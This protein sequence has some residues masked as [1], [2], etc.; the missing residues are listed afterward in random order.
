MTHDRIIFFVILSV[1]VLGAIVVLKLRQRAIARRYLDQVNKEN[2]ETQEFVLARLDSL[3]KLFADASISPSD[4]RQ[5]TDSI[6][7]ELESRNVR[8]DLSPL[9]A[10]TRGY[11]DGEISKRGSV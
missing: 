1:I 10:D 8:G 9:I 4:L 5:R 3:E 7:A 11:F 6:F 2:R